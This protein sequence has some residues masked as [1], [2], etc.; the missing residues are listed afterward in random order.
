MKN[1]H[2]CG[3]SF[4]QKRHD[5]SLITNKGDSQLGIKLQ[6]LE[7][8]RNNRTRGVIAT[9]GIEGYF[10]SDSLFLLIEWHDFTALIVT[11]GRT[12]AVPNNWLIAI[13]AVLNLLWLDG[14]MTTSHTL[15]GT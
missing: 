5:R 6:C 9:H 13:F 12:H 8:S 2:T 10:H 3:N 7:S 14:M 1:S 15:A 4:A 11:T